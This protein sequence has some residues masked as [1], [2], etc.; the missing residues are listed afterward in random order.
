MITHP[1]DIE[2]FAEHPAPL[3]ELVHS[4]HFTNINATIAYFGPMLYFLTRAF[5]CQK[6]LEIGHAEG[7]TAH[8]LAHAVKDNAIRHNYQNAMY[9][10]IDIIQ[11]EKVKE[12]LDRERL[13]NILIKMDTINLTEKTFKD[14]QFDL[15]FQD[16]AHDTEHVLHEIKTLWPQLKGNGKGY[17]IFHDCYGPSEDAFQKLIPLFDTDI[18][19][20]RLDDN[21]YG[22]AIIRKME[23]YI[24]SKH[25]RD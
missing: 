15:I 1:K 20:I 16:G 18:E 6:V 2:E 7:Y 25:W 5:L 14:I 12:W 19:W 4:S 8:Y 23:G 13:P 10:G 9:Y 17:W 21:I 22:L 24:E 3:M 11:T